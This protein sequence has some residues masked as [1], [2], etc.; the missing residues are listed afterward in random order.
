MFDEFLDELRRRQAGE[1]PRDDRSR[2]PGGDD[3]D[4][5]D[6]DDG[7]DGDR[8][9][10]D[11]GGDRHD[12]SPGGSS[13]GNRDRQPPRPIRPV[14]RGGGGPSLRRQVLIIA[15]ILVAVFV[16]LMLAIGV[17]LWTDAIWYT[18]VGYDA[19]FWRRLWVQ[20]GLFVL[21]GVLVLL[22]LLGNLWLA[23]RLLPPAS[24]DGGTLRTLIDRFNEA[25]ERS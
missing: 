3:G 1:P 23:G 10:G 9:D 22:V 8:D 21:G 7:D 2:A 25:A 15:A 14:R 6:R 12:D 4:D 20:V 19:V 18:S 11:P 5:G 16:V 24:G 17:E 13:D